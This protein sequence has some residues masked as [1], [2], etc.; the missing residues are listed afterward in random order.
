M[1]RVGQRGL[2]FSNLACLTRL[3]LCYSRSRR[4][5]GTQRSARSRTASLTIRQLGR[6]HEPDAPKESMFGAAVHGAVWLENEG[7]VMSSLDN[8]RFPRFW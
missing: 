1:V 7:G 3:R 8:K 4:A 6:E 2:Q 5:R